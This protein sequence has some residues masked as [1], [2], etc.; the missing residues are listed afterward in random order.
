MSKKLLGK[1]RGVV[2]DNVDPLQIGRIRATVPD[3]LGEQISNWAMPCVPPNQTGKL[4][5]ALPKI[6]A[7]VWIEFE[8]GDTAFPIWSGG[9]Y[10]NAAET[11]RSLRQRT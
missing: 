1:F 8:Q 4:G 3:L 10:E 6:G 9:F 7:T 2:E 5:S 11:P